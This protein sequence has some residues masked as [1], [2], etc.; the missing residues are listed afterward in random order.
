MKVESTRKAVAGGDWLGQVPASWDVKPL[1]T[2][3]DETDFRNSSMQERNLLSLSYGKVIRK[4]IDAVGGLL[5]ESFETYQIVQAG[6]IV[7]RL[8]D[9]QND[10]RS[11]RVGLVPERGIIT[12]AYVNLR[13]RPKHDPRFL[14]YQLHN[15]DVRKVFYNFGGG[16]RQS[17]KFGDLKRLPVVLP[18]HAEQRAVADFLDRETVR[19]DELMCSK[20]SAIE[21]LEAQKIAEIAGALSGGSSSTRQSGLG[22]CPEI[23][24]QWPVAPL[25]ARY[26]VQ[27]GKML[28]TARISGTDLRP[29]IRNQDVQ[30]D[31]VNT[32]NLPFMDFDSVDRVKF[33]LRSGDLLVCEG[34]DIGRTAVWRGDVQ[35][36]YFQKA[37]HRLRPRSSEDCPRFLYYLMYLGS[38][39][40]AFLADSNPNTIPHLTAEKL[41]R[42]RF[43]FPPRDE[44]EAIVASLDRQWRTIEQLRRRIGSGSTVLLEYRSSLISAAVTGQI[45]VR[46]YRPQEAATL[47]Q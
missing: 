25:Y 40:G 17:M 28:D 33:T 44:Q 43:P 27:L 37:L 32:E 11:L 22:W 14:F 15:A 16:V 26:S 2:V 31:W 35:E 19:I 18:P 9:L 6:D 12:A 8:T 13:A 45:D 41:R 47:C 29:Y 38:K 24:K 7:L 21:L 30:W 42:Q 39:A 34:G 36:C 4:D 5:P 3:L 10:Q 23:P 20:Q 1:F 46:H